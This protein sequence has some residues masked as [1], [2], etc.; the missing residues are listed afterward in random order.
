MPGQPHKYSRK[1]ISMAL[2]LLFVLATGG[3]MMFFKY[4]VKRIREAKYADIRAIAGL[5]SDEIARWLNERYFDADYFSSSAEFKSII[6]QVKNGTADSILRRDFNRVFSGMK[7]N[8]QYAD[9]VV[10]D[11]EGH[12]LYSF[13]GNQNQADSGIL[14]IV[15]SVKKNQKTVLNDF[16]I[17]PVSKLIHLDIAAPVYIDNSINSVLIFTIDPSTFLYPLIQS[18]PAPSKTSETLLLRSEGDS[19]LF[20]NPLKYAP[21][22]TLRLRQ[23]L[24]HKSLPPL[25]AVMGKVESF[26]GKDYMGRK[27]IADIRPI[28]GTH[29][30]MVAKIDKSEVFYELKFRIILQAAILVLFLILISLLIAFF[31][32]RRQTGIYEQLFLREQEFRLAQEEFRITLYSI[33]DAVITTDPGGNIR[34]M[35]MA[36]EKLTGWKESEAE[37]KRFDDVIKIVHE[38]SNVNIDNPI[39]QVL[40]EGLIKDHYN[41]A[42][43]MA[44]DGKKIPVTESGAIVYDQQNKIS[45][46]VLVFHDITSLKEADEQIRKLNSELELRVEERTL[47]LI[48][49]N[50]ELEAFTYSVSHDL[51]TPLRAIDGFSAMLEMDYKNTLNAE[52]RRLVQVVRQNAQ[53]M[54]VLIDEL[55]TFSR[56]GRASL[57]KTTIDMKEMACSVIE[58]LTLANKKKNMELNVE[59]LL[60]VQ[61]DPG[62]MRQV[63]LN[64]LSNAMKFSQGKDGIKISVSSASED[65]RIIYCIK[66][67]G[68]GFDMK[69]YDK[70]FGV[71]QRLHN[72]K[73]F[74]GTGV[75]LAIVHQVIT[76]HNGTIWA[77]GKINEGATFCFSLPDY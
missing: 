63:W 43:L 58:E 75:G 57:K 5:K 28:K 39:R 15:S 46:V 38:K 3:A 67:N 70:L 54:G 33:G 53:K 35:N 34:H 59:D 20:L 48:K 61:G 25:D 50:K 22:A 66:D 30:F 2:A 74:E 40:Q 47:Q 12:I 45:G 76:R 4:Q 8:H 56:L 36:A 7:K 32:S 26:Q 68:A 11:L 29:W 23:P 37:R 19:I 14:T 27:V 21:D 69:Y 44:K 71:F 55:L 18:W 31:Y 16:S 41:S 52:G 13:E 6:E 17:N 10:A 24:T 60:P 64:L 49:T 62:M 9:V 77:E 42:V 1:L 73:E 65:S 51:R 72:D